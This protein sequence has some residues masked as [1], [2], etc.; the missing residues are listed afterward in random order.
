MTLPRHLSEPLRHYQD[1]RDWIDDAACRN[2]AYDPDW[3]F[4]GNQDG[5]WALH[6]SVERAIAICRTCPV[7][8]LCLQDALSRREP[9][10]VW[11]G[12]TPAERHQLRKGARK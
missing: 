7:I 3:W 4:H 11:G 1:A 2:P 9:H 5:H 12:L 6:P 10:G 8:D